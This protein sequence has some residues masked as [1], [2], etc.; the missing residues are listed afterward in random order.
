MGIDITD[1]KRAEAELQKSLDLLEIRVRERTEELRQKNEK[2]NTANEDLSAIHEELRQA[3]DELLKNNLQLTAL[4]Q[5]LTATQGELHQYVKELSENEKD[6]KQSETNLKEALAE[7]EILLSEIHHRVKN[8]LAAFISL[9]SLDGSYEES[10]AG[11]GLKKDLQNRARTMALIHETLY[12]TQQYAEVDMD[13]Y[14]NTL[15]GQV[16]NSYIL[17]S[18][19]RIIID[20]K[21]ITLDLA[22][23]RQTGNVCFLLLVFGWDSG[24]RSKI[25]PLILCFLLPS[26]YVPTLEDVQEDG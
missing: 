3:N 1:R 7:K 26:I 9:L 25:T 22:R 4:N 14:L 11:R 19:I 20:A 10:Q 16:V 5:E 8:N 17:T 13:I 2:L 24:S 23:L 18:P 21:G 12:R 6:L 15:V